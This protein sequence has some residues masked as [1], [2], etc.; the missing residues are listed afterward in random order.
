M[1]LIHIYDKETGK[2]MRSQEPKLDPLETEKQGHPVYVTY[3][4]STDVALPEYGEHELPF[5]NSELG[6][7][8]VKGQ[9]KNL[10]VYN[11]D[12]KTFDYCYT[13]ELAEN[14]VF[15]DDKEGIEKKKKN[16]EMYIVDEETWTIIPNPTYQ[17]ALETP[18][19]FPLNHHLYKAM[20]IDDNT[21]SKILTGAMAGVITFPIDIWD[22][23]KLE[24]NMVS[25]DQTTFGQL[26]AFLANI[27]NQAFETRKYAQSTLLPQ[28]QELE[29]EIYGEVQTLPQ[30]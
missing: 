4:N 12:T 10:E 2:F 6:E 30:S 28:I 24:E 26:C 13:D 29:R 17:A 15:I 11:K 16:Y 22:A 7:W 21:Y 18:V 3:A 8:E 27:Q 14:Q 5:W 25:M 19:E 1:T 9:Y 20:W 23:T